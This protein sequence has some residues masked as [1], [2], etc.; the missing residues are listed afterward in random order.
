MCMSVPSECMPVHHLHIWLWRRPE[1]GIRS[2]GTEISCHE[3]AENLAPLE[4]Q[5]VC[6]MAEKPHQ[7]FKGL[8][9]GGVEE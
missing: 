2:P 9:K 6:L 7:S 1:S 4:G 3:G 8:L 5:P